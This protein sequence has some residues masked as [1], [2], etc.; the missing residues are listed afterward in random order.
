MGTGLASL[1]SCKKPMSEVVPNTMTHHKQAV[2]S[3]QPERNQITLDDNQTLTYDYLVVAPGLKTNFAGIKGLEKALADPKS[4]VSS[5]Y[6]KG[7][8]VKTWESIKNLK[9]VSAASL[10]DALKDR[11]L[12][13][14]ASLQQGT[15]IFTQP[16]GPIKCAGAPQK[17]LW[18]ADSQWR[19]EGL[20]NGIEPIFASGMPS[21]FAVPKYAAALEQLRKD[22]NVDGLFTHNL[23]SVD[24]DKKVAT[25]TKPDGS[26]VDR[27]FDMLHAV[28]P[29]GPLDFIK[30]SPIADS[31]GWVNVNKDTAQH[32]QFANIFSLG[33]ASSLPNS[34]TM[35]AAGAQAPVVV[36]NLRAFMDGKPLPGTY[37]ASAFP[38]SRRLSTDRI[39]L[40]MATL[41]A[42][43]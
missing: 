7:S 19:R 30:N 12:T 8:A 28:P 33:D 18:M 34:K 43:C 31:A 24:G 9:Q 21:M 5:I 6:G 17:V 11:Q 39:W 36:D 16:A 3:F 2:S 35:A 38:I 26:A 42:L 10:T 40:Q 27:S 37:G 4:G 25:F 23:T 15:A 14:I 41:P 22:R 20:R 1:D 13:P 29:Q 32:N